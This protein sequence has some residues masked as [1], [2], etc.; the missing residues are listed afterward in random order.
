MVQYPIRAIRALGYLKAAF[1]DAEIYVEDTTCRNMHLIIY[2][3]ILGERVRLRSVNQV[4]DRRRVLAACMADQADDGRR[5]LYL[6][7]GDFDC[8]LGRRV[9]RLR[10]LYRLKTYDIE[11]LLIYETAVVGVGMAAR[12]NDDE[13]AIAHDFDFAVWQKEI[14]RAFLPL[15]VVYAAVYCIEPTL[16]T[17][18]YAVHRLCDL[19][20]AELV[21][22]GTKIRARLR[23]LLRE[24]RRRGH[25]AAYVQARTIIMRRVSRASHKERFISGKRY[26]L[27]ILAQRMRRVLRSRGNDDH[28]KVQL[29]GHSPITSEAGL[30][31]ALRSL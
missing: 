14:V 4:G 30:V 31:R 7:D 23:G 8:L 29:A 11:N 3:R 10:F 5:K 26:I 25:W 22:S 17:V 13:V 20:Q 19:V 21:P 1:N 2:R 16:Q 9:P 27:P 18:G 12:P 15:F 24:I 28:L 6:I